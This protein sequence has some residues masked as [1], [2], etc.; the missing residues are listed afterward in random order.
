M[1]NRVEYAVSTTA[2]KS[3]TYG[4]NY[5]SGAD[6]S[7]EADTT[8]SLDYIEPNIG[9]TLGGSGTISGIAATVIGYGGSTDGDPDYLTT[10][11][12][13]GTLATSAAHDMMFVKNPGLKAD[14]TEFTGNITIKMA[15]TSAGADQGEFCSLSK[16]MAIVLP[17]VPTG[18]TFTFTATGGNI[19]SGD[20]D[21]KVEYA[22][23]T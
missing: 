20:D 16:G 23:I 11:S 8:R 19:G 10:T 3:T 22:L 6:Q 14:G 17:S 15:K 2:I 21:V 12:G 13:S 5:A 1:A 9:K 18:K 4:L 7:D